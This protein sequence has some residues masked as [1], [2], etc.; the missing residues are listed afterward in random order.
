MIHSA[1]R[2]ALASAG[3]LALLAPATAPAAQPARSRLP[4][5]TPRW[6]QPGRDRGDANSSQDVTV[7]VFLPLRNAAAA[8]QAV[9]AVSDPGSASYGQFLSPDAFRQRYAPSS[10]DVNAVKSFLSG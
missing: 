8:S 4:G 5:S 6:A 10:A 7:K 1:R 9:Q 2:I 3:A